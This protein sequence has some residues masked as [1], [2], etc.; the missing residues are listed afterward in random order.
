M[1]DQQKRPTLRLNKDLKKQTSINSE[2]TNRFTNATYKKSTKKS[3]Q[4][5]NSEGSIKEPKQL[6][7]EAIWKVLAQEKN[8]RPINTEASNNQ[9]EEPELTQLILKEAE[10]AEGSKKEVI[11]QLEVTLPCR[12]YSVEFKVSNSQGLTITAE[13]LLRSLKIFG[14]QTAEE[15][16]K[17]FNYNK[18]ETEF[19]LEEALKEGYVKWENGNIK[20]SREGQKLFQK[21]ESVP[22]TLNIETLHR[23]VG[24]NQ[25]SF[26]L[27]DP[28]SIS[29]FETYLPEIEGADP[30]FIARGSEFV[31]AAFK[32]NYFQIMNSD[33]RLN[34]EK[35]NLYSIS[36]ITPKN[37][38]LNTLSIS[39]FE[40]FQNVGQPEFEVSQRNWSGSRQFDRKISEAVAKYLK[41]MCISR[42]K[43]HSISMDTF[44]KLISP[45]L[46][47][48]T[49]DHKT[50]PNNFYQQILANLA[51]T[52]NSIPFY[53]SPFLQKQIEAFVIEIKK[54][55]S[56]RDLG[57]TFKWLQPS[58]N[59]WG[60]T[61]ML[62]NL[63]RAI[64]QEFENNK[65]KKN[66]KLS[67]LVYDPNEKTNKLHAQAFSNV[68]LKREHLPAANNILEVMLLK[69]VAAMICLHMPPLKGTSVPHGVGIVTS[70][71]KT[72]DL[73]SKYFEMLE[74]G[75]QI[76]PK[77][78][79]SLTFDLQ[80]ARVQQVILC[81]HCERRL[82]LGP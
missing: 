56:E 72:I 30:K 59:I 6:K 36:E 78:C 73:A 13:F 38:F 68:N 31:P 25:L 21:N 14:S 29:L 81:I 24:F 42:T 64:E 7:Q 2:N 71:A 41:P 51:N 77:K 62:P 23:D 58:I 63:V 4:R 8:K 39:V 61:N 48:T 16:S 74:N 18:R 80:K 45:V 15:V 82:R 66:S 47:E 19:V 1:S 76:S 33:G 28:E 20:L 57:N 34:K 22:T 43:K 44:L 11:Q 54:G 60:L 50:E 9:V 75:N 5:R 27:A 70:D 49:V 17:L 26:G 3:V 53:G 67:V 79:I 52:D 32:H 40:D 55:I 65:Q 69:N 46:L 10:V 12:K 37:R 35:K